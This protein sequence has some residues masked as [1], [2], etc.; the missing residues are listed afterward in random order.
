M[1]EEDINNDIGRESW[2][3]VEKIDTVSIDLW[4]IVL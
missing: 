2:V 1:R 4:E 3:G